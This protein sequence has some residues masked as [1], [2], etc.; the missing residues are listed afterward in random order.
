MNIII[1][2][3]KNTKNLFQIEVYDPD[4]CQYQIVENV[5]F[6]T[7]VFAEKYGREMYSYERNGFGFHRVVMKDGIEIP[8]D[9][10]LYG[11]ANH[12]GDIYVCPKELEKLLLQHMNEEGLCPYKLKSRWIPKNYSICTVKRAEEYDEG[13]LPLK[14]E[15]ND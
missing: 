6:E 11:D 12:P 10:V 1:R 9:T 3:T 13:Y 2:E 15:W 4:F 14:F 7:E 5:Y 8:G